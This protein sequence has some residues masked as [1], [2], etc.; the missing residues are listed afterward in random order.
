LIVPWTA[1]CP[2]EG[3]FLLAVSGS[4]NT[5]DVSIFDSLAWKRMVAPSVR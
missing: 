2:R 5:V 4:R 1:T 3:R